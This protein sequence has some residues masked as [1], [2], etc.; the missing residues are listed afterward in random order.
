ME[1]VTDIAF[2][3]NIREIR[4]YEF[5]KFYF[6]NGLVISEI[7]EGATFAW[8]HAE[9][10]IKA[11]HEIFG[12]DLPIIYISNRVNK[13]NVVASD[14]IKF[15]Q[16]RHNL[17]YYGIVGNNSKSFA[18]LVLERM[19][20][21]SSMRKFSHIQDAIDWAQNLLVTDVDLI[22]GENSY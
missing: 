22:F 6:F 2:F 20:F 16:H 1:R 4:E 10:A 3:N 17:K 15:Y 13:Y 18:S 19:F 8:E 14:W 12:H 11:A 7:A 9:K 21:R 5:G